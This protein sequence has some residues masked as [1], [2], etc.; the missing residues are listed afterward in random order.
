VGNPGYGK[1]R[2]ALE[3]CHRLKS[4]YDERVVWIGAESISSIME[5]IHRLAEY[6]K[7]SIDGLDDSEILLEVR[8]KLY[9]LPPTL[10]IFDNMDA[11]RSAIE[12]CFVNIEETEHHLLITTRF[13][14]DSW[15]TSYQEMHVNLFT[16]E[17][18]YTLLR[19][20][21]GKAV[22]Q[23]KMTDELIK[24]FDCL[25]LALTQAIAF[26][27]KRNERISVT[28]YLTRY[29]QEKAKILDQ[30]LRNDSLHKHGVYT[31]FSMAL[32]D[33]EQESAL[34]LEIIYHCAFLYPDGIKCEIFANSFSKEEID[35]VI[36]AG[37]VTTSK[38][39]D[40][41]EFMIHRLVQEVIKVKLT[42]GLP[43][44]YEKCMKFIRK[45]LYYGDD[46]KEIIK[47]NKPFSLHLQSL[48]SNYYDTLNANYSVSLDGD[49]LFADI[50]ILTGEILKAGSNYKKQIELYERYQLFQE[51]RKCIA[52][53]ADGLVLSRDEIPQV[54]KEHRYRN[55]AIQLNIGFAYIAMS[56][57]FPAQKVFEEVKT[58]NDL[59]YSNCNA[60]SASA[61]GGIGQVYMK[62][63]KFSDALRCVEEQL[64]II[65]TIRGSEHES[66]YPIMNVISVIHESMGH[67][68]KS[69]SIQSTIIEKAKK[70]DVKRNDEDT[71]NSF[72]NIGIAHYKKHEFEKALEYFQNALE[73][74]RNIFNEDERGENSGKH[75]Q[76]IE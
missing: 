58:F 50:L 39:G 7:I 23:D 72:I 31:T 28:A 30:R 53:N 20:K 42:D 34:S 66:I 25:P 64:K 26:M 73:I 48:C 17:E 19:M 4:S 61:L 49:V 65:Q 33:L 74:K 55:S 9:A 46:M 52:I 13:D 14:D 3:C 45:S 2:L 57:Y 51:Q 36:K 38:I 43:I 6:M 44:M 68:D 21:L 35:Y 11:S 29:R 69:L 32:E 62:L 37:L 5:N 12:E 56:D 1:S 18:A 27:T 16:E 67:L 76:R 70:D 40:R 24:E 41:T 10:I 15:P 71:A 59:L 75:R 60:R 63:G 47:T 22:I 54:L 8:Q